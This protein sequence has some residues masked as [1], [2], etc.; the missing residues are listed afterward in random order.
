MKTQISLIILLSFFLVF[1]VGCEPTQAP[2]TSETEALQKFSLRGKIVF[3]SNMDGD[4]EIYMLTKDGLTKLTDNTWNDEYPV[5]SPDGKNIAFTSD[6]EGNYDIFMMNADGTGVIR[7]TSTPVD[8]K[9]PAWFPDAK[10]IVYTQLRK[11]FLKKGLTLHRVDILTRK[12]QRV[13]PRYARGHALSN[14]SP[15]GDLLVFT[16]KRRIGWDVAV[17]S[18]PE[19]KIFFLDEGGKSCRAR[20]SKD[21]KKLAYVSSKADGKGDIWIMNPDGSGKTRVTDRDDTYDYFPSWSPDG[22]YIVFNSS[23]Q[24]DHEGDWKILVVEVK[25]RRLFSVYDSPGNDVFPDWHE[26]SSDGTS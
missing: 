18:I 7:L 2:T 5:W 17:Y 13:I 26:A 8:E 22:N 16:G 11:R 19:R 23:E 12:T 10:S 21:G 24:H 9:E 15:L 14:V 25:S 20:F 4:N 1:T 3:Q 6:R